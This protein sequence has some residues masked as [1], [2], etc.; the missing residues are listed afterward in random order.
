MLELLLR[1]S[2]AAA[3]AAALATATAL[4]LSTVW[5]RRLAAGSGL[6]GAAL[7]AVCAR[8]LAAAAPLCLRWALAGA[9]GHHGQCLALLIL[10]FMTFDVVMLVLALI[11]C[12]LSAEDTVIVAAPVGNCFLFLGLCSRDSLITH[13]QLSSTFDLDATPQTWAL[14]QCLHALAHILA[15][16]AF[17]MHMPPLLHR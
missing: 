14:W 9:L 15:P 3:M 12:T 16:L 7:M 2:L 8:L 17:S 6:P 5:C 13:K 11:R 10:G 1:S 4:L